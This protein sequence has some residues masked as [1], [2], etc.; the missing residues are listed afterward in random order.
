MTEE[1]VQ[2]ATREEQWHPVI[3]H[4]VSSDVF[5]SASM[6]ARRSVHAETDDRL[7]SSLWWATDDAVRETLL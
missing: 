5:D 6:G 7:D 1:D 4:A 2:A 3:D